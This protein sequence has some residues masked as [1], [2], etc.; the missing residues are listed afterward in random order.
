MQAT[1]TKNKYINNILQMYVH[2]KKYSQLHAKQ[3]LIKI[4][5]LI[6]R[7]DKLNNRSALIAK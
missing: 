2:E 5:N 7:T 4:L 1:L 3:V 6:F